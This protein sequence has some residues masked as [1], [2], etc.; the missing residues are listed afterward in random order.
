MAF[1][2]PIFNIRCRIW[3]AGTAPP[4]APRLISICQLKWNPSATAQNYPGLLLPAG[5]D[6]RGLYATG[7]SDLIEVPELS[8]RFYRC[9]WFDDTAK[10]FTNEY[11]HAVVEWVT[12]FITPAP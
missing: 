10:G 3:T 11:R 12:P 7:G 6:V 9:V 5:T 8:G 2:V 4:A 1:R